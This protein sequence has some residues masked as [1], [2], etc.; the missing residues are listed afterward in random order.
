MRLY[1]QVYADRLPVE[2]TFADI[3]NRLWARG[4]RFS[5]FRITSKQIRLLLDDS[6]DSEECTEIKL[7]LSGMSTAHPAFIQVSA[8][9]PEKAAEIFRWLI[10]VEETEGGINVYG[11]EE[12]EG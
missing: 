5:L 6:D 10:P 2:S 3:F 4:G 7:G 12:V 8:T 9:T 1:Y 11:A